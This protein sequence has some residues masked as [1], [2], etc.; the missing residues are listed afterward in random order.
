MCGMASFTQHATFGFWKGSL[1]VGTEVKGADAMEQFGRITELLDLPPKKTL[2][3]LIEKAMA[4]NDG[5]VTMPKLLNCVA[6]LI[7]V[8]DDLAEALR[9]IQKDRSAFDRFPPVISASTFEWITEAKRQDSRFLR[10]QTA[11]EQISAEGKPQN[12]K[13]MK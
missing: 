12:W 11:I 13:Y 3:A 9:A 6:N 8:P 7:V 4:L 1:V 2:I 10:L 5:G